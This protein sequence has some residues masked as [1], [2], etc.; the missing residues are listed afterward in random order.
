MAK[1]KTIKKKVV[2][3]TEN[4]KIWKEVRQRITT[5]LSRQDF[6]TVCKLHAEEFKHKFYKFCTCN[7]KMLRQWIKEL[8]DKLTIN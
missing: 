6:E 1:K 3:L 7:K 4:Q 2:V 5:K 8:D